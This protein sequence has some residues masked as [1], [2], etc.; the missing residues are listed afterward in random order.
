MAMHI[1]KSGIELAAIYRPLN[2][3]YLNPIMGNMEKIYL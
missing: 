1:E 2:N 3:K